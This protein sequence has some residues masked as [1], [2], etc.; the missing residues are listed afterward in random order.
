LDNVWSIHYPYRNIP[1]SHAI[2][3]YE[4][5]CLLN[6]SALGL[7]PEAV[8]IRGDYDRI[9]LKFKQDHLAL[10]FGLCVSRSAFPERDGRVTTP[11]HYGIRFWTGAYSLKE[12][13]PTLS[14]RKAVML[15]P[16]HDYDSFSAGKK[17]EE[18]K[19]AMYMKNAAGDAKGDGYDP[20]EIIIC[21][22]G[23]EELYG[24]LAG[25]VLA[26]RGYIIFPEYDFGVTNNF[27][28]IRGVP[29]LVAVKLGDFQNRL[30][31]EGL[32]RYG[33]WLHEIELSA[34]LG[35]LHGGTTDKR[36]TFDELSVYVEVEDTAPE[37]SGGYD[38]LERYAPSGYFDAG[39]LVC[40]RREYDLTP[41]PGDE[42]LVYGQRRRDDFL[43]MTWDAQGMM[44]GRYAASKTFE[45]GKKAEL[46][47]LCRR[48]IAG[49][50]RK[51]RNVSDMESW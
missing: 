27:L 7:Q 47:S 40:P 5:K 33:G 1:H 6:T 18:E 46:L 3:K 2:W 19:L 49:S 34:F 37:G 36:A 45:L 24:I 29:D 12:Y 21:C 14:G 23:G 9:Y 35:G 31:R 39:M 17:S 44:H 38:Q 15:L 10:L 48:M 13:E 43:L 20:S 25:F 41:R 30:M 28:P 4:A 26:E 32:I 11:L 8:D 16:Q 42:S 22:T 50:I 51:V